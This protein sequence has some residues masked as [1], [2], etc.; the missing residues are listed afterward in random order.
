MIQVLQK[1]NYKATLQD[2][3]HNTSWIQWTQGRHMGIYCLMKSSYVPYL[4]FAWYSVAALRQKGLHNAHKIMG[5]RWRPSTDPK[6][7]FFH[8]AQL[9]NC[10]FPISCCPAE[11]LIE[12]SS[13]PNTVFWQDSLLC[14]QL[15][16]CHIQL[17]ATH[18]G[19]S[20]VFAREC[21]THLTVPVSLHVWRHA[22]KSTGSAHPTCI[23]TYQWAV[24][25]GYL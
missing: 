5:Y 7:F 20:L 15:A 12:S 24:V 13:V 17:R 8:V 2:S 23:H 19:D 1:Q 11:P 18:S 6:A 22:C 16:T 14:S 3:L 21:S 10:Q 9:L 4:L 25:S